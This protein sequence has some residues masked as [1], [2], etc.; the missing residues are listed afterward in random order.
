M[1]NTTVDFSLVVFYAFK[2]MEKG[3]RMQNIYREKMYNPQ[4]FWQI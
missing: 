2:S 4:A 3:F 1:Y